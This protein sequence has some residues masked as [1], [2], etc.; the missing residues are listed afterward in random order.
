MQTWYT[1]TNPL[2]PFKVLRFN[3]R[4]SEQT[5][6]GATFHL[7]QMELDDFT[8]RA[9]AVERSEDGYKVD[10]ESFAFW[11]ATPWGEFLSKQPTEP[12]DFRVTLE[13]DDYYNFGYN[14][15]TK[16]FCYKLADPENWAHCWGYCGIDSEVGMQINRMIRRQR[17]IGMNVVKTILKLRFKPE[18][19][20]RDHN[21]VLIEAVVHDGWVTAKP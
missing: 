8:S 19:E 4:S 12:F 14:D 16:L 11:S 21:Q 17:Q 18:P 9:I 15:R 6:D 20:A 13:I 10:W 3:D 1:P 2:K 5:I 7:L